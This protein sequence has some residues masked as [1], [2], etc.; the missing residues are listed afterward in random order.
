MKRPALLLAGLLSLGCAGA[1]EKVS[2]AA[3]ANIA[4]VAPSLNAAFVRKYPGYR[5]EFTFGA[6]GGLVTQILNG[7]PFQVF[8][9]ADM[10][11]AQK[12]VD[13]GLADGPPRRTRW[14]R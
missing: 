4:S 9:S 11:F 1:Q 13:A 6:S 5:A 3:A 8:L 7:A 12:L 2:V 14:A 10:A